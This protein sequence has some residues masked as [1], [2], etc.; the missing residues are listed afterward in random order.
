ML[1]H[2]S[3]ADSN[4]PPR[5]LEKPATAAGI[6]PCRTRLSAVSFF[7]F[8]GIMAFFPLLLGLVG[9]RV[10]PLPFLAPGAESQHHIDG[11][12]G[13]NVAL[14]QCGAV[15]QLSAGVD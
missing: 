12:T 14:L 15:L 8:F 10:L 3:N 2:E 7:F 1:A 6:L 5:G 4:T 13:M 9:T 11:Y